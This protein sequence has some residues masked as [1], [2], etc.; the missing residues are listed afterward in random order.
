[1]SKRKAYLELLLKDEIVEGQPEHSI[2]SRKTRTALQDILDALQKA[3]KDPRIIALSLT[4]D[5]RDFLE[6]AA[7]HK[8]L[9]LAPYQIRIH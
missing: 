7:R 4:L 3:A 6:E 2:F 9:L 8:I 5:A 1:M